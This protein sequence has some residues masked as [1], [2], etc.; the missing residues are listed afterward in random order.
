MHVDRQWIARKLDTGLVLSSC[1]SL[2]VSIERGRVLLGL[3]AQADGSRPDPVVELSDVNFD[4]ARTRSWAGRWALVCGGRVITDVGGTM[5]C[6]YRRCPDGLWISGSVELLRRLDPELPRVVLVPKHARGMDWIPPP[7]TGIAGLR[8]L[9]PTQAL[10]DEGIPVP[11]ELGLGAHDVGTSDY[12]AVISEL[13]RLLVTAL[14][15]LARSTPQLWLPLTAG[16]DSRTLLAAAAA[17]EIEIVPFTFENDAMS[18]ADRVLPP[19]LARAVGFDHVWIAARAPETQLSRMFDDHTALQCVD[20]DRRYVASRQWEALPEH[21]VTVGGGVFEVGRC[22]YHTR[23]PESVETPEQMAEAVLNALP[24]VSP[25]GVKAWADWLHRTPEIGMDWR[26]RFYLEQRVAGWLASVAQGIDL[27]G[28]T[29][30]HV[31]SCHDIVRA[32]LAVPVEARRIGAH[33]DELVLRLAPALGR[34]PTNRD[35]SLRLRLEHRL[36]REIVLLRRSGGP[37]RY[38]GARMQHLRERRR[39]RNTI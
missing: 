30:V 22:Y 8:R 25:G 14:R 11:L 2:P 28:R 37:R 35:P 34:Y 39:L 19:R 21:A 4:E 31:A 10:I 13:S 5:G 17:A 38:V 6:Y 36:K 20:V 1:P 15:N 24:S 27:T 9:L 32:L 3:A 26:D 16:R 18:A 33:Q 12:K 23:L 7:D 29:R